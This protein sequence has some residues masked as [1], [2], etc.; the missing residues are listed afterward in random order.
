MYVAALICSK[1]SLTKFQVHGSVHRY[2]NSE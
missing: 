1:M 2:D